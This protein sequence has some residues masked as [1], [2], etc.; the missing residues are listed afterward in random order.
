[1]SYASY[2]RRHKRDATHGEVA[3][4]LEE[5][6][7]SIIDLSG[8]GGGVSDLLVGL[9]GVTDLVEVKSTAKAT[10]T[11]AQIKLRDRWRGSPFVRLENKAQAE[12]WARRTRHERSRAAAIKNALK[13]ATL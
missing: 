2:A 6:G 11:D 3:K 12:E 8:A 10:Y 5:F 1:M 7:F 13:D 9:W 4:T